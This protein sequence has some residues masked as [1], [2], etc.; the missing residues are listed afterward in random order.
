MSAVEAQRI[1]NAFNDFTF[2]VLVF[3]RQPLADADLVLIRDAIER[4]SQGRGKV[5][6][7]K[8]ALKAFHGIDFDDTGKPFCRFA[9][10]IKTATMML[11]NSTPLLINV[12]FGRFGVPSARAIKV[13]RETLRDV[14]K[15]MRTDSVVAVALIRQRLF[16]TWR[17]RDHKLHH[18]VL[19]RRIRTIL[20][21]AH[22]L[23][24]DAPKSG[25]PAVFESNSCKTKMRKRHTRARIV[26][27]NRFA[28]PPLPLELWLLIMERLAGDPL[29]RAFDYE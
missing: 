5:E 29:K 18:P 17:L 20:M 21:V 9:E 7:N 13:G 23:R 6:A 19:R 25:R 26:P 22:R 2:W 8:R 10:L 16:A 12:W 24:H 3:A 11:S 4:V 27:A 28:L 14:P 15:Y 1:L